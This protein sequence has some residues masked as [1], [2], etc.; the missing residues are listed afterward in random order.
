[1]ADDGKTIFRVVVPDGKDESR[2]TYDAGVQT[3]TTPPGRR[4]PAPAPAPAAP[5]D[6]GSE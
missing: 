6:G 1:M 5:V 4:E 2:S 3:P